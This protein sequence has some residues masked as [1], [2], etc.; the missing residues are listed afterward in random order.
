MLVVENC[1]KGGFLIVTKN[2]YR[3]FS[4]IRTTESRTHNKSSSAKV[5]ENELV[6]R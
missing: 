1:K 6:L 4:Y 2:R 5:L 3:R